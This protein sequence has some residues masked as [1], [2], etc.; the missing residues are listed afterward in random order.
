MTQEAATGL[1]H[2]AAPCTDPTICIARVRDPL[3]CSLGV[4]HAKRLRLLA[5]S[6][7]IRSLA[8]CALKA[9]TSAPTATRTRDLLL[10]RSTGQ[11]VQPGKWQVTDAEACP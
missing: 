6:L 2:Q 3:Y 9:L 1:A 11:S 7:A 4:R 10:R 5:I 8:I